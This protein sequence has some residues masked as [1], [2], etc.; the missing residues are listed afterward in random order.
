MRSLHPFFDQ[1]LKI[2]YSRHLEKLLIFGKNV[3]QNFTCVFGAQW[4]LSALRSFLIC[5]F[6]VCQSVV[7]NIS[8][9]LK[10]A[11]DL[12]LPVSS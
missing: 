3:C 9:L 11:L 8:R 1:D 4:I 2:L 5:R 7:N 12:K 10:N 6:E